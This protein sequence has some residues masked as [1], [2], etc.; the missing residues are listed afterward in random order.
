MRAVTPAYKRPDVRGHDMHIL[1]N[2]SDKAIEGVTLYL[3]ASEAGELRDKLTALLKDH[4]HDHDHVSDATDQKEIT[5]CTYDRDHLK[6]FDERS[7]RLLLTG[8]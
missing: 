8:R 1:D 3:T 2:E 7:R 5:I 6:H 4:P